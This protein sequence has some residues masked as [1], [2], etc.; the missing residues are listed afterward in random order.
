MVPAAAAD[1]SVYV[2]NTALGD[3]RMKYS[4]AGL[5]GGA[6]GTREIWLS[7]AGMVPSLT[8]GA[9]FTQL[10][11][12]TN[13]VNQVYGVFADAVVRYAE[14]SVVLPSSYTGGTFTA[15]F[16]WT[17]AN[18]T[19]NAVRWGI[20]ARAFTDADALDQAWGT[21]QF[22]TD[23]NAGVAQQLRISDSTAAVTIGGSPSAGKLVHFKV[24]RLGTDGAD[25][26]AAD[27]RLVG[28]L[29]SF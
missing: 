8:S 24:Q 23:A 6:G 22:V 27:A 26:L 28:V 1:S 15:K 21:A 14:A 5:T 2:V 18:A 3:A 4:L 20:Q 11:E 10:E 13:D 9:T 19:S 16:Y 17:T 29:L 25:T 7:A 12:P